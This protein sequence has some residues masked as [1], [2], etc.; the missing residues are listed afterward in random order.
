MGLSDLLSRVA[1]RRL[2]VLLVEG[3]DAFVL[4]VAA[5]RACLVRGWPLA[6]SP[7]DADVLLTCRP[8]AGSLTRAVD[9][10][11]D[12]MPGPRARADLWTERDLGPA[13]DQLG[14]HYQHEQPFNPGTPSPEAHDSNAET[15]RDA[16]PHQLP[17]DHPDNH[18]SSGHNDMA[19]GHDTANG[20]DMADGHD[21]AMAGPG[22]IALASGAQDRDGLEMDELH[23]RL[24]PVLPAWPAGLAVWCTLAGDVVTGVE[25]EQ[26]PFRPYAPEASDQL[27]VAARL[28]AAAQLLGLAGSYALAEQARTARNRALEG[29]GSAASVV[30]V[31]ALHRRVSRSRVLRWSLG[32]LGTVSHAAISAHAW[33]DGWA[34]DVR[35]RLLRLLAPD[36]ADGPGLVDGAEVGAAL[37]VLLLGLDLAAARLVVASLVAHAPD[38]VAALPHAAVG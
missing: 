17:P 31:G 4:R 26:A 33:P 18:P 30:A 3:P 37:P 11:F 7:A 38:R 16:D 12:Q 19:D 10:V 13:L 28:D 20:H 34:G 22:G 24:G 29:P 5:E 23:V 35:A 14:N 32:G 27:A 15:G 8:A 9:A 21:M 2:H 6:M 25:V 1:V 36:G